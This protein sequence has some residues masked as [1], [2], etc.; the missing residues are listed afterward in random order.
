V[1]AEVGAPVGRGP[2][3]GHQLVIGFQAEPRVEAGAWR[4]G[5]AREQRPVRVG[6][7]TVGRGP[8]P[9]VARRLVASAGQGRAAGGEERDLGGLVGKGVAVG[10]ADLHAETAGGRISVGAYVADQ[11]HQPVARAARG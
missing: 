1:E 8:H 7:A 6:D 10:A 4:V 3:G 9:R 5:K 11:R 2:R